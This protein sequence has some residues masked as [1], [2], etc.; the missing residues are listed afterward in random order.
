MKHILVIDDT[1]EKVVHLKDLES[2]LCTVTFAETFVDARRVVKFNP[3]KFDKIYLDYDLDNRKTGVEL[4]QFLV[5]DKGL[6]AGCRIVPNSASETCNYKIKAEI[7]R[8]KLTRRE[9]L[10]KD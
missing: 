6:K 7:V 1:P 8:L 9:T 5:F 4:L 10:N 2:E 3:E